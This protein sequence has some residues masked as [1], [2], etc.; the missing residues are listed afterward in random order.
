M[1]NN[2]EH[3]VKGLYPKNQKLYY[4]LKNILNIEITGSMRSSQK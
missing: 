1:E 3:E 4:S 2:G